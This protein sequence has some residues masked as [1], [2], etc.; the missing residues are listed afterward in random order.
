MIP[1]VHRSDH[2]FSYC[3]MPFRRSGSC[4]PVPTDQLMV[5]RIIPSPIGRLILASDGCAISGVWMANADPSDPMWSSAVADDGILDQATGELDDY[6]AGRRQT[7]SV[8][9][10]PAG[11]P[12][13]LSVWTALRSI[14]FGHTIS[15]AAL[16]RQIG[17]PAAV[18]AVGAAN[19]RNP[20]P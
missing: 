18:R 6:F 9:L 5:Y 2:S 20:I 7:F 4:G 14:P 1:L 13:Q 11:T 12:F 10:A 3:F 15:Y 8:P 17:S 16:A 19:G